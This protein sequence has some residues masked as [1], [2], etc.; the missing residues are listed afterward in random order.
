MGVMR[1]SDGRALDYPLPANKVSITTAPAA[2]QQFRDVNASMAPSADYERY[3][4]YAGGISAPA[5]R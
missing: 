5:G 3:A 2:T 1:G 4:G